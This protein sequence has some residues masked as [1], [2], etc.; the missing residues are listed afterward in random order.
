MKNTK[1]KVFI[2]VFMVLTIISSVMAI[3]CFAD[4]ETGVVTAPIAG[5]SADS[6]GDT[7]VDSETEHNHDE[8]GHTHADDAAAP[9]GETTAP[10]SVDD[11]W[12]TLSVSE[13]IAIVL[14]AIILV[15]AIAVIAILAPKKSNQKKK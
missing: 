9:S 1:L 15:V 2:A 5:D 11:G 3:T 10:Q 7:T 6:S 8:P 13:Y 4:T 14:G 12:A